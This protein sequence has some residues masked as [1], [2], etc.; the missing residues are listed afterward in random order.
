VRVGAARSNSLTERMAEGRSEGTG[1]AL[2]SP[3]GPGPRPA[4]EASVTASAR[5]R[6]ERG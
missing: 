5:G 3:T 2:V 6:P 1:Q 4:A